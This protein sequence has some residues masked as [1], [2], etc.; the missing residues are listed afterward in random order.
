MA[1]IRTDGLSGTI[2]NT[3][4]ISDTD[5][6]LESADLAD[7]PEVSG[8]DI[9]RLTFVQ[10]NGIH[11]SSY[12]IVHVTA[13]SVSATTATI[14]RGQE[15]STQ[16]AWANG[17]D[18]LHA[19]TVADIEDLVSSV[20]TVSTNLSNHES[21]TT[22]P[23]SVTSDQVSAPSQSEFDDHSARHESGGG[24]EVAL[25]ASQT[26]SGTFADARISESSV[27]QHSPSQSDFDNHSARHEN[28]GGDEISVAGLSG[29][30][31]DPQD[32]KTHAST[33][34]SGNSDEITPSDIGAAPTPHDLAASHHNSD[35]LANLNSKVS[36]ATLISEASANTTYLA[37][38]G[39]TSPTAGLD[40]D[41]QNLTD[42]VAQ[43]AREAITS[44]S[45]NITFDGSATDGQ[46]SVVVATGTGSRTFDFANVPASGPAALF[47]VYFP[48][49]APSITWSGT[50]VFP[51]G[52][53]P[54]WSG[55]AVLPIML[56]NGDAV[57]GSPTEVA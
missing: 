43:R 39:S 36:D 26:T 31:A 25:D 22:N 42:A 15:G 54:S 14:S 46:E 11:V 55:A 52:E 45:G 9:A 38:D 49:G 48:D 6:T 28:G 10:L 8:G 5:T 12:E 51:G 50:W 35:T 21:D 19:I 57:V 47:T 53:A 1:T 33:H 32:P 37:R 18:W 29:D 30:L 56:V 34:A 4:G 24:D 41:G 13:H 44:G 7:L 27:T 2:E 40:W 16:Q 23:H 20:D 3:G 17:V